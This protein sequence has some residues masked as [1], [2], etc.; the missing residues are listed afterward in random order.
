MNGTRSLLSY[1]AHRSPACPTELK[2]LQGPK[3]KTQSTKTAH[4]DSL[5]IRK[6][7]RNILHGNPALVHGSHRKKIKA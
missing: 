4:H 6:Y 7:K 1:V 5:S 2:P 3:A